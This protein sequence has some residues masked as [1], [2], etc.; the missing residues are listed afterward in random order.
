[1]GDLLLA[2][3]W[4]TVTAYDRATLLLCIDRL[5]RKLIDLR[6]RGNVDG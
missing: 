2:L 1:L 6:G 5:E 3:E 4:P